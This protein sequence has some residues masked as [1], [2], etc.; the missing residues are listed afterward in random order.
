[1]IYIRKNPPYTFLNIQYAVLDI[2]IRKLFTHLSPSLLAITTIHLQYD[3]DS[4][5]M[6]S[7]LVYYK[8]RSEPEQYLERE[9]VL[10]Y[11]ARHPALIGLTAGLEVAHRE[12]CY[13]EGDVYSHGISWENRINAYPEDKHRYFDRTVFLRCELETVFG[14]EAVSNLSNFR[15]EQA[16]ETALLYADDES[17]LELEQ[18]FPSQ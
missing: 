17:E 13:H 14:K 9:D 6:D 7:M 1:M 12:W 15:I 18:I 4:Q 10:N 5:S 3:F 16:F 8:G 2:E 11:L